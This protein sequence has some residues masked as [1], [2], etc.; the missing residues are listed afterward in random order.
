MTEDRH[1][2]FQGGDLIQ[3]TSKFR[4][5]EGTISS[6]PRREYDFHQR[7]D[8]DLSLPFGHLE[9]HVGHPWIQAVF[10]IDPTSK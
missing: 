5:F 9:R 3:L 4:V 7:A 6:S 10:L 2:D 8:L 1:A